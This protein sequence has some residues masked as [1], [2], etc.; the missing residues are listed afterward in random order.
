MLLC[1]I[2]HEVS[3]LI[4]L[5]GIEAQSAFIIGALTAGGGTFGYIKVFT[6]HLIFYFRWP[7]ANAT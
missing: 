1:I 7:V 2:L 4:H 3:L 5:Q 6:F